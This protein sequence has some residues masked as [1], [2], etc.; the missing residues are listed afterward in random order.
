MTVSSPFRRT[1]SGDPSK[2][3]ASTPAKSHRYLLIYRPIIRFYQA[4]R[5]DGIQAH[6]RLKRWRLRL[7]C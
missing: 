2:G 7:P 3:A 1:A 4:N 5:S 6:A